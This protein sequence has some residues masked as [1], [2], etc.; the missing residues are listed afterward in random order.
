M[1]GGGGRFAVWTVSSSSVTPSLTD[2]CCLSRRRFS[3]AITLHVTGDPWD[4]MGLLWQWAFTQGT[5]GHALGRS[6]E[7]Q[8][9]Q[10][11]RRRLDKLATKGP[12]RRLVCLSMNSAGP[13]SGNASGP[14]TECYGLPCFCTMC[15]PAMDARLPPP[16]PKVGV[17]GGT[18]SNQVSRG[19]LES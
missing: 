4:R 9:L 19:C 16:A 18:S 2:F 7:P 3:L 15:R 10:T 14:N 11:L 1:A 13:T 8:V 6:R 12:C 5:E 17:T